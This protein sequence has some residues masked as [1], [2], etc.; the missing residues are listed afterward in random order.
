MSN[1]QAAL[2]DRPLLRFVF[3]TVCF[4]VGVLVFYIASGED[5]PLLWVGIAGV[6]F[7]SLKTLINRF[8]A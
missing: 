7:A 6:V 2:R 3:Y 1:M 4:G 5:V 8:R